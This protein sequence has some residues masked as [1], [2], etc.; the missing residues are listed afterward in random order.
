M[1]S[2]GTVT[3]APRAPGLLPLKAVLGYGVLGLGKPDA[4]LPA[5]QREEAPHRPQPTPEI[6]SRKTGLRLTRNDV[7]IQMQQQLG[8]Q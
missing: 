1:A 3:V 4:W 7:H 5:H 2:E 8:L 6:F